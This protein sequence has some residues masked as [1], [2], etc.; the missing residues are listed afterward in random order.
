MCVDS[1]SSLPTVSCVMPEVN[2]VGGVTSLGD[3]VFAVLHENPEKIEVYDANTFT[4][5]RR[6][7]VPGLDDRSYG[8]A[9]CPY[10]SLCI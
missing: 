3:D 2:W 4:L 5:Q 7:T 6:I 10:L 9:A 8:L 1:N